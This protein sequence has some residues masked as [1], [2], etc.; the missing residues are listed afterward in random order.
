MGNLHDRQ[1]TR[2]IKNLVPTVVEVVD[3]DPLLGY[4][5]SDRE[6]TG[7]YNYYG[8]LKAD[9]NFY[10]MRETLATGAYRYYKGTINTYVAT[11]ALRA[12]VSITYDYFNVIFG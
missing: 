7:T 1:P 10:I 5:I 11:W 12:D 8:Y 3:T 9:G 6:S 2:G 4:R